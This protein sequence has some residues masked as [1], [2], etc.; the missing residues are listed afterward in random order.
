M[1]CPFCGEIDSKVLDSRSTENGVSIRRRRECLSCGK[2]F[3]SY[4]KVE[5]M[6]IMVIKKDGSRQSFNRKKVINGLLRACEKR[7]VSMDT[8]DNIVYELE[9]SIYNS[10]EREITS[11]EIGEKVLQ[12]L[13]K[14]DDVAFI[15][16][17]SVYRDFKDIK[18][19][20]DEIKKLMNSN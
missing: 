10:L 7:P 3:T 1:K 20:S 5:E 14:I 4:E 2:R 11:V 15:R 13:K 12:K 9:T 17:A 16:F 18:T 19:F 6:P 8:I